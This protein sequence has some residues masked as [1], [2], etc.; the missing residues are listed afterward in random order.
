M[1]RE[2]RPIRSF[3]NAGRCSKAVV[4]AAA[5]NT[6]QSPHRNT[7][8]AKAQAHAQREREREARR[9]GEN[10]A[11]RETCRHNK[12]KP[13]RRRDASRLVMVFSTKEEENGDERGV[14]VLS[15]PCLDAARVR[16]PLERH[17]GTHHTRRHTNISTNALSFAHST[18]PTQRE[19]VPASKMSTRSSIHAHPIQHSPYVHLASM[20]I[21][22]LP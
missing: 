3:L 20:M 8:N 1:A 5:N 14:G 10:R 21:M 22:L 6:N 18:T 9:G 12:T 11:R 19:K 17:A 15:P 7:A 4:H 2:G 13:N 16:S